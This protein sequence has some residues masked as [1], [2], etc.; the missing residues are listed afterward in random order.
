M[1]PANVAPPPQGWQMVQNTHIPAPTNFQLSN[2]TGRKRAL[3]IGINYFGQKNQLRGY[4]LSL[5][6]SNLMR[7]VNLQVN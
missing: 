3:L 7:V 4:V 2:C 5:C 6:L 1:T